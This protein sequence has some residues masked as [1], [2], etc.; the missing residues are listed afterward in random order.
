MPR[1]TPP[2]PPARDRAI[3]VKRA[4][5]LQHLERTASFMRVN[6][7][8]PREV[9]DLRGHD[10]TL[11]SV[12][13]HIKTLTSTPGVRYETEKVWGS[14]FGPPTTRHRFTAIP[15][16]LFRIEGVTEHLPALPAPQPASDDV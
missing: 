4:R 15:S 9:W 16:A 8:S 5:Y 12:R 1:P 7:R 6:F 2:K 10:V 3:L 14:A 11:M 13:N